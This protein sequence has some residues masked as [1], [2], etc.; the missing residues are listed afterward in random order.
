MK[1]KPANRKVLSVHFFGVLRWV[2]KLPIV[3][4]LMSSV[5]CWLRIS[6]A[7]EIL[8]PAFISCECCASHVVPQNLSFLIAK[9]LIIT[10]V[11]NSL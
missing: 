9:M 7:L 3:S 1:K 2:E 4:L 5:S 11:M 8:V 10:V 6:Q